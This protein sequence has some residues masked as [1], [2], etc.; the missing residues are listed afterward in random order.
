MVEEIEKER[1]IYASVAQLIEHL[2]CTQ[3]V[4][5]LI[6]V[7][8]S[9]LHEYVDQLEDHLFHTQKVAG[10]SPVILIY[11]SVAQLEECHVANVKVAG[12][13]PVTD[14]EVKEIKC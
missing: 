11:V 6:P 13:N 14:I 8:S 4:A 3:D 2:F 12:A 7:T 1:K 10:S 5:G 9:I